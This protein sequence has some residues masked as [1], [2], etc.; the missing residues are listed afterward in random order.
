MVIAT[1]QMN[2]QLEAIVAAMLV[3]GGLAIAAVAAIVRVR[4][5]QRTIAEILDD[6]MG[7]T[8]VPVEAV[9]ESRSAVSCRP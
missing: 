9:S 5:K 4:T 2:A 1:S 3:G 6:T 7:T 8:R